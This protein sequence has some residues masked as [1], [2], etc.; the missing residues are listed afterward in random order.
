MQGL[1]SVT[2]GITINFD[3]EPGEF[4]QILYN[5]HGHWLT[6][7][8]VGNDH[9]QVEVYDSVYSCC[10]MLC[11]AQIAGLLSTKQPAIQLKYMDVR[12][13]AGGGWLENSQDCSVLISKK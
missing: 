12:M 13:Q 11:I 1:Q 4:V 5:G 3:I 7:S 10:P 2:R 8:A 6:V 9:P